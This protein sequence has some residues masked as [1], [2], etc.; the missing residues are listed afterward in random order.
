MIEVQGNLWDFNGVKCITTNGTIKA[1]GRAVMGRGCAL[2][3]SKMFAGIDLLLGQLIKNKGNQVFDLSW[4]LTKWVTDTSG[5]RYPREAQYIISFPVKHQWFEKADLDLI[6]KSAKELYQLTN[7]KDFDDINIYLPR[8][9]CGNGKL[10][11]EQVKPLLE[12]I[13][14][15]DRYRIVTF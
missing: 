10:K 12:P 11:W 4:W 7:T 8:P 1:N 5:A 9:G 3:A 6:A 15:G 2:E 13:L 14:I